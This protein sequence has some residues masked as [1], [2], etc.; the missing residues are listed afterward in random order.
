[1]GNSL[2]EQDFYAWTSQQAELLRSRQLDCADLDNIAEEIESMGRSVKRELISRLAVLL[3]HLLKWQHQPAFRS[4]SWQLTIMGQRRS[5][6]RHLR[7]NPSLKPQLDQAMADA[8]GDAT[9][10]AERETGLAAETFPA[11]CP[12]SFEQA[13]SDEFW[14]DD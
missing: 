12:F 3:L 1:M 2:Y 13:S 11:S 5:L 6:D 14:P 9:I 10:E 4:R 8:Y 7:D